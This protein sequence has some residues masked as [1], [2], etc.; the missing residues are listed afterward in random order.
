MGGHALM[1]HIG[2][3]FHCNYGNDVRQQYINILAE[4]AD[5]HILTH[6]ATEITG[7]YM[8]AKKLSPDLSTLIRES[9]YAL[10]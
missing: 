9:E 6:I 8:P 7:K 2:F 3:R 1:K 4:L 5:S 10:C